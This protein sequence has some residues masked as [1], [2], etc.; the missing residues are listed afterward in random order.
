MRSSLSYT[1]T[2]L[3]IDRNTTPIGISV[4]SVDVITMYFYHYH[5]MNYL[6]EFQRK[7]ICY[8]QVIDLMDLV[9]QTAYVNVGYF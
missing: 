9:S 1:G 8:K 5:Q 6:S 7:N 4:F 2:V 3:N